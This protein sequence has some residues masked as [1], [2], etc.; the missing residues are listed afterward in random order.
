MLYYGVGVRVV[1]K[2]NVVQ[3][4]FP[5]VAEFYELGGI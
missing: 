5:L 2:L 4:L 3:N 1:V